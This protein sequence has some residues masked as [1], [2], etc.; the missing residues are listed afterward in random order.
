MNNSLNT[1]KR[2]KEGIGD[3]LTF[4]FCL[5]SAVFVCCVGW[6]LGREGAG[7]ELSDP[8]ELRPPGMENRVSVDVKWKNRFKV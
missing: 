4:K 8:Q 5:P 3:S 2:K 7:E 6:P 1:S